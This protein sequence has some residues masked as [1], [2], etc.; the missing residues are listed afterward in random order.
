MKSIAKP[1]TTIGNLK[2]IPTPSKQMKGR[3]IKKTPTQ[4]HVAITKLS[5]VDKKVYMKNSPFTSRDKQ[6]YNSYS[7]YDVDINKDF[8]ATVDQ[9]EKV[10]NKRFPKGAPAEVLK[11]LANY[12]KVVYE[13]YLAESKARMTAPSMAVVG[14]AG[15]KNFDRKRSRADTMRNKSYDDVKY[16][17]KQIDLAIERSNRKVEVN[18]VKTSYGVDVG[19]I[20]ILYWTNNYRKFQVPAKVV[21]VNAKT[22]VGELEQEVKGYYPI[23][24]KITVPMYGT[25]GN[26]WTHADATKK[27]PESK[28]EISDKFVETLKGKFKVG[29]RVYNKIYRFEGTVIKINKQTMVIKGEPQYTGDKGLRKVP[30]DETMTNKI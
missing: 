19:D 29:D 26:R 27:A 11:A 3:S 5:N 18:A 12:R 24:W 28:K 1:K 20:V 6:I 8:N 23:G 25:A 7:F 30:I 21:K 4:N 17:K 10:V 9:M 16:A 2:R 14:P 22:L 15:Y 13:S